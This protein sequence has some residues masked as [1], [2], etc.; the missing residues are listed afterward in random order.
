MEYFNIAVLVLSLQQR[1]C[2]VFPPVIKLD[3]LPSLCVYGEHEAT[4]IQKLKCKNIFGGLGYFFTWAGSL[5]LL[6]TTSW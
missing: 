6:L 4:S 2:I 3:L 5:H 1:I